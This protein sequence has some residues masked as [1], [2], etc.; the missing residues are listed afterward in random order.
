[1]ADGLLPCPFC[2]GDAHLTYDDEGYR[3]ARCCDYGCFAS[4]PIQHPED[5]DAVVAG[6]WNRRPPL[7]SP[8]AEGAAPPSHAPREGASTS[9]APPLTHTPSKDTSP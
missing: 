7:P 3:V 8:T 6:K 2:G 1:M 4:M 5:G 9:H